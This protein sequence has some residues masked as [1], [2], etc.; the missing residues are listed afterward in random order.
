MRPNQ[1]RSI[2]PKRPQG[3]SDDLS[4]KSK[5]KKTKKLLSILKNH[6]YT[7]SYYRRCQQKHQSKEVIKTKE[8]ENFADNVRYDLDSDDEDDHL[9]D[10]YDIPDEEGETRDVCENTS[11][12][13][14]KKKHVI[15]KVDNNKEDRN[16]PD[17]NRSIPMNVTITRKLKKV[18]FV[19]LP[20]PS[21]YSDNDQDV[22]CSTAVEEK[23]NNVWDNT[24]VT[25]YEDYF[26]GSTTTGAIKKVKIPSYPNDRL[27][28]LKDRHKLNHQGNKKNAPHRNEKRSFI[29]IAYSTILDEIEN[30]P[31]LKS[32]SE[33][34]FICPIIDSE[35]RKQLNSQN[36]LNRTKYYGDSYSSE[37]ESSHGSSDESEC[38]RSSIES[39]RPCSLDVPNKYPTVP[40]LSLSQLEVLRRIKQ[41]PAAVKSDYGR[42]NLDYILETIDDMQDINESTT[43]VHG[44]KANQIEYLPSNGI[45]S[46]FEDTFGV[47]EEEEKSEQGMDVIYD[48]KSGSIEIIDTNVSYTTITHIILIPYPKLFVLTLHNLLFLNA[49]TSC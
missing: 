42:N 24:S 17:E 33:A 12:D 16:K 27:R 7:L 5:V 35:D 4:K 48:P 19:D 9:E 2:I 36:Y 23:R 15:S 6:R 28:Y 3:A 20:H 30:D 11:K 44:K 32:L 37:E 43:Q 41:S 40:H 18:E 29:Q 8:I 45:L 49:I 1:H 26:I 34:D 22:R 31:I 46:M 21:S 39:T 10:R 25:D 47:E 38:P 14:E 13:H